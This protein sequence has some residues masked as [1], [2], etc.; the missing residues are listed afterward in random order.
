MPRII[1]L[2]TLVGEYWR[3]LP[4]I[5]YIYIYIYIYIQNILIFLCGKVRMKPSRPLLISIVRLKPRFHQKTLQYKYSTTAY[6]AKPDV[7]GGKPHLSITMTSWWPRWCLKSPVSRFFAQPFVQAQIRENIKLRVTSLCE[8]NP[9]VAGEF[10]SQ[11][12]SNAEY[13][14]MW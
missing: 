9:S 11:R 2:S 4:H 13:V 10:P 14:S 1:A 12:A 6:S 5:H 3:H 7:P 8:G